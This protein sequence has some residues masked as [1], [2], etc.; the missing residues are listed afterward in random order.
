MVPGITS[1]IAVAAYA[2]IPVTHRRV[3]SLFTVV[4]GS[5]DPTKPES[6]VPWEVL[7][8]TG[9]T[10]VVLMGWAALQSILETLAKEGM[11]VSTPVALIQWGTWTQQ[12]TV[13]GCLEDV[14]A[15]GQEADLRPP[16][17][18]VIGP[19]VA[20]RERIRWFDQGDSRGKR[21]LIT[22]SRTQAS[23]LRQLLEEAGA[24]PV[25]L[26]SIEIAPLEDYGELDRA[27]DQGTDL[28]SR[29]VIF[30]STNAVDA[31]FDRL[32]AALS[33]RSSVR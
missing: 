19:V 1:A 5:E 24:Q 23:Q 13:T 29:W 26:P 30:A 25:E 28:D 15:L 10:L 31:V 4:S 32:A 7:A 18:A 12:R 3:S 21:V 11:P 2:G 17:V 20:L 9:G 6:T 8:R 16:V 27:L 14:V 22:R 33:W